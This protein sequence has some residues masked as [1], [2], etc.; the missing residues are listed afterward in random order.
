MSK[1]LALPNSDSAL[2]PPT[3]AVIAGGIEVAVDDYVYLQPEYS[4]EPYYIGRIMEFV[5]VSRVRQPRLSLSMAAHQKSSADTHPRGRDNACSPSLSTI[6]GD[7]NHDAQLHVR[8]AWFQRPRDLPITRGRSKDER[9]LVAT[10]HSDINP[11]NAIK[12]KCQVRHTA[13]IADLSSWKSRPDHYY[14]NQLFDRYSTRLY[15][16]IPVAQIRNAPQN[17]LQKLRDTY[18][19]IFAEG[20]K[21]SDLVSTRRACTICATLCGVSDGIK[22]SICEKIYHMTCLDPPVTRKP[23][24]GYIWNCA[25]CRRNQQEQQKL[26]QEQQRAKPQQSDTVAI[27]A[28]AV[29]PAADSDAAGD[30]NDRKRP[31]RNAGGNA[32]DHTILLRSGANPGTAAN[33]GGPTASAAVSDTESRAGSKRFKASHGDGRAYGDAVVGPIP[34]PKN[35]GLWPFRYF[36]LNTDI[37]DVLHDDE[38]IYPRAVSR[39]GIRYQ[40]VVPDMVGPSGPELDKQLIAKATALGATAA[41]KRNGVK[42]IPGYRGKDAAKGQ[43]SAKTAAQLDR[44]WDE[45]EVRRGNHEDQLF[46]K[47]PAY[48]PDEELDTYMHSI[49]PFLTRHFENVHDFTL[50]DC[51]DAALH[52]LMIHGFDVEEA[53][54]TIPEC[55]EAYIR[56]RSADDNWGQRD[57]DRF[58][59]CLSDFGANLHAIHKSIPSVSRRAVTLRYYLVRH[60]KRGRYLLDIFEDGS[61]IGQRRPN[62]GQ[63]ESAGNIHM[64]ASSEAGMSG[65]NTPTGSPHISGAATRDHFKRNNGD[66]AEKAQGLR[67]VHCHQDCSKRW[68]EAPAELAVYNTRS[69]RAIVRRVICE[70]CS[71]YWFHYATMPDQDAINA[72]RLRP[73]A[74]RNGG[75]GLRNQISSLVNSPIDTGSSVYDACLSDG[76]GSIDTPTG[77]APQSAIER[78]KRNAQLAR[79]PGVVAPPR[80]R[81]SHAWPMLPC[82]VCKMPTKQGDHVVLTCSDCGLCV[83]HACSGY[84]ERARINL[85]RWKCSVCEN[86]ANPTISISYACILCR[87][88]APPEV[89]GQPRPLMWR[90]SGNNWAHAICALAIPEIRLAYDHGHVIVKGMHSI[91]RNAWMRPCAV[92]TKMAGAV[93]ECC[94]K[95]CHEGV[96]PSCA[97][98]SSSKRPSGSAPQ[99][100]LVAV[101]PAKKDPAITA[102]K[103][104]S[105]TASCPKHPV[106]EDGPHVAFGSRDED[107]DPIAAAVVASKLIPMP[108]SSAKSL[109][110]T[111]LEKSCGPMLTRAHKPAPL[112]VKA[113]PPYAAGGSSSAGFGVPQ[114]GHVGGPS[115]PANGSMWSKPSENPVCRRCSSEFSPI[116]WPTSPEI[117]VSSPTGSRKRSLGP[118]VQCHRCYTATNASSEAA[119]QPRS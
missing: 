24:K 84:P 74:S 118:N 56:N 50:L 76:G 11:V 89:E 22:C 5:F 95:K 77:V 65:L 73:Q 114:N 82:S 81:V 99:A 75:T 87:K 1:H 28:S 45:I 4:E 93:I 41:S 42:Q 36:G 94:D 31:T 19:F 9:M 37:D 17:V 3:S 88:E 61:H 27:T 25:A 117:G 69:S 48:L 105:L 18:E 63:G 53:L 16:I 51:Q 100:M 113:P 96:H 8:L 40:A 92:C 112:S 91:P 83:H 104:L 80:Q 66:L 21:I 67:C 38:R 29:A 34:R 43:W 44:A 59:K 33:G 46:F 7:T 109:L 90:T 106:S 20:Q 15:D 32:E 64:E 79:L 55:P 6:S 54:I 10:M 71:A 68:R 111:S 12:G 14:Y 86:V 72:R 39:I 98:I 62:R 58:D 102:P 2:P 26:Q 85:K 103:V 108:L 97:H 35:R 60:T 107:G 30:V 52:G 47:Q 119:R 23:A 101:P 110:Q 78:S 57:V 49:L 115:M 70:D 13:E 116:W